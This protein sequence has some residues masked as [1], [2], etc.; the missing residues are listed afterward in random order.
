MTEIIIGIG[1]LLFAAAQHRQTRTLKVDLPRHPQ[2]YTSRQA[3][4]AKLNY[5]GGLNS[6][7]SWVL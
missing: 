6:S 3:D 1:L 4:I 7:Q 2:E 5:R